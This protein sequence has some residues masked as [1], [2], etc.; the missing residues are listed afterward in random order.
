MKGLTPQQYIEVLDFIQKYHNFAHCPSDE[1]TDKAKE[2]YPNIEEYGF[3]IKYIDSIYDTRFG[4]IWSISF[5]GFKYIRFST[6]HFN[7]LLNPKPNSFKFDSLYDW[8]MAY[9][10][11]DWYDKEVLKACIVKD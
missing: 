7:E 10:K 5:R 11:G 2:L 1:F 6:N 9:L 4:D 3:N 8:V